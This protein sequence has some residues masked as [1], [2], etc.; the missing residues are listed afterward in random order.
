[1]N[2]YAMYVIILI[3]GTLDYISAACLPVTLSSSVI[4]SFGKEA[5][6]VFA[7][8][9]FRIAQDHRFCKD[10][11]YVHGNY[12]GVGKCN[13]FGSN[14]D[15]G[16][17]DSSHARSTPNCDDIYEQ[18]EEIISRYEYCTETELDEPPQV[19]VMGTGGLLRGKHFKN[20]CAF[21]CEQA[22]YKYES[23]RED[24]RTANVGLITME[25]ISMGILTPIIA[26]SMVQCGIVELVYKKRMDEICDS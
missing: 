8:K 7:L 19:D 12:C 18:R 11:S 13:I 6:C 1:M 24:C 17:R 25:I 23:V 20:D 16:C 22:R 21:T 5:F 14:C 3:I 2:S 9:D 15:G 26:P 4:R 10:G